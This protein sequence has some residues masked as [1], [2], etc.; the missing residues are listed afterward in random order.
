MV[1][2]CAGQAWLTLIYYFIVEELGAVVAAGVTYIPPVV[3]L[4]IGVLLAGDVIHPLGY[5]AMVLILCGVTLLQYGSRRAS[6][7]IGR[8]VFVPTECD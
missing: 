2:G 7:S 4:V 1:R 3:A 5:L 6:V 8:D